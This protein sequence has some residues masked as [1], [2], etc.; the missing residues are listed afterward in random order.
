MMIQNPIHAAHLRLSRV[1]PAGLTRALGVFGDG[2]HL[3]TIASPSQLKQSSQYRTSK[4][5]S[6]NVD[7]EVNDGDGADGRRVDVEVRALPRHPP[8]D[9]AES[10]KSPGGN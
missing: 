6:Q 7:V 2:R 1:I 3:V 9:S 8:A 5:H 4:K 10:V